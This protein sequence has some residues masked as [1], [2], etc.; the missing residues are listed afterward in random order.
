MPG[1]QA[2]EISRDLKDAK[3]TKENPRVGEGVVGQTSLI[4][5]LNRGNKRDREDLL[6][7]KKLQAVQQQDYFPKDSMTDRELVH[8]VEQTN[9]RKYPK[10]EEDLLL[11]NGQ[12]MLIFGVAGSEKV[13]DEEKGELQGVIYAFHDTD[14]EAQ[15]YHK[16][17]LIDE[18]VPGQG[19]L[20]LS[21]SKLPDA[22][23]G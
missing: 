16:T 13:T 7:M 12:D 5:V 14:R 3:Y 23:A 17:G 18:P 4:R 9:A 11:K 6:R 8:W 22:P 19:V 1:P 2:L 15:K 21:Y 20:E 10:G